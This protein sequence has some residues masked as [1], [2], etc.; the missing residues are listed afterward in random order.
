[1]RLF[2][3]AIAGGNA[4][5]YNGPEEQAYD[6]EFA[7]WMGGG[8]ADGV[9]SGTNAVFLALAALELPA[10]SEVVIPPITDPGGSAPVAILNCI[11]VQADS[12]PGMYNMGP[13]QLEA[14]VT[15][16][17]R[18]VVVA[19]IAG[20]PVDMDGIMA[21]ARKYDLRVVED[22]AQAH[23]A[24]L[25]G[26]LVGTFGDIAAFSTMFGK[27]MVTGGQ[28]GVVYTRN[29]ALHWCGRRYADRGKPF[30]LTG[31]TNV[32]P[33]LNMN[34]NDLA[35]AIGREQLRK[36]PGIVARRRAVAEAIRQG[37]SNLRSVSLMR[38]AE[39]AAPSYWFLPVR[40]DAQALSVDKDTFAA[41]VAA[42]GIPAVPSY[43]FIPAELAWF[44]KHAEASTPWLYRGKLNTNPDLTN[45]L[46]TVGSHF[47]IQIHEGFD[48]Q[49]VDDTVA[50]L[51]KVAAAY[52]R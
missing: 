3:A 51:V 1:M 17:T 48:T 9:N 31:T 18:A 52:R 35:A 2:D 15:E 29:E 40:V 19:H 34:L 27:H 14:V 36:L 23:G 11:P 42:E 20:M 50:A 4:F 39:G 28:G 33:G 6:Q 7:A 13:E 46:A 32:V 47:N 8:F 44:R 38:E 30:N 10:G 24:R 21:V 25:N 45:V 41:A 12:A 22:C 26:R 16:R 43:R 37:I 49:A 5:G